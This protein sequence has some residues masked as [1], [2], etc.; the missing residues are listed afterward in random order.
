MFT[1]AITE[2]LHRTLG[3]GFFIIAFAVMTAVP[4]GMVIL[5]VGVGRRPRGLRFGI[6]SGLAVGICSS[7]CWLIVPYC[8]GYPNLLG[9]VIGA[10]VFGSGTWG[11]EIAVHATNL[12]LW[13]ALGW[14][15][16]S[17]ISAAPSAMSDV[18]CGMWERGSPKS[19]RG[20]PK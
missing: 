6:M 16:A 18:G 12:L 2:S 5:F 4:L 3:F 14:W 13:P 20:I 19:E 15:V 17:S 9:A 10:I 7:L 11:Q 8:G 1:E